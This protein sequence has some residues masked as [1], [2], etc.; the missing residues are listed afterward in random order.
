MHGQVAKKNKLG[1]TWEHPDFSRAAPTA[2][3]NPWRSAGHPAA[4]QQRAAAGGAKTLQ[5]KPLVRP[6][7]TQ[8]ALCGGTGIAGMCSVRVL[9]RERTSYFHTPAPRA[10][11][12][13]AERGR[14]AWD[15]GRWHLARPQG[16]A[17]LWEGAGTWGCPCVRTLGCVAKQKGLILFYFSLFIGNGFSDL[18]EQKMKHHRR[19][20]KQNAALTV[21]PR[22]EKSPLLSHFFFLACLLC[23]LTTELGLGCGCAVPRR[24]WQSRGL[25]LAP[26][27]CSLSR[28]TQPRGDDGDVGR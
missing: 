18:L 2:S 12:C 28:D 24:G 3:T 14:T 7:T 22:P 5:Q 11:R 6:A 8:P 19:K 9:A 4:P 23:C 20:T 27:G 15:V 25:V 17:G 16:R 26:G 13:P 10:A 21:P 1:R